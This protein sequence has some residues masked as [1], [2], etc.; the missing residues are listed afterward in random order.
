MSADLHI[1]PG[2]EPLCAGCGHERRIHCG[3]LDL[4]DVNCTMNVRLAEVVVACPCDAYQV[5]VAA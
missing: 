3:G 5:E 2:D 4:P 1:Q